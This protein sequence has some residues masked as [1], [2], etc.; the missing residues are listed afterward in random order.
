[1][2]FQERCSLYRS[3][4]SNVLSC[5]SFLKMTPDDDLQLFD[6]IAACLADDALSYP[7]LELDD[8]TQHEDTASE[9][10]VADVQALAPTKPRV[11][12]SRNFA[13]ERM[14]AELDELR[15]QSAELEKQFAE[16]N[17]QHMVSRDDELLL[18]SW[19][20]VALRQRNLRVRAEM[21]NLR[22]RQQ[23]QTHAVFSNELQQATMRIMEAGGGKVEDVDSSS[24]SSDTSSSTS[25]PASVPPTFPISGEL[26]PP[27]ALDTQH[28]SVLEVLVGE[29][30]T[31]Y[32]RT[33]SV[34]RENGL[35][36]WQTAAAAAN[37]CTSRLQAQMK[38]RR[39]VT[40]P[41]GSH[42]IE[43]LNASVQRYP[44]DV[45][46]RAAYRY[47]DQLNSATSSFKYVDL[48]QSRECIGSIAEF[49][50]TVGGDSSTLVFLG[51]FKTFTDGDGRTTVVWRSVSVE[52]PRF[53]GV[54]VSETAWEEY[55]NAGSSADNS[56]QIFCSQL[57]TRTLR[58]A[59]AATA[60]ATP[61]PIAL[62][63][64]VAATYEADM[65]QASTL[66]D[67]LLLEEAGDRTLTA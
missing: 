20:R 9:A 61:V 30:E 51:V 67:G 29:L 56:F 22:L 57:E 41:E 3:V 42:Y 35:R 5:Q 37:S 21:E 10:A 62:A 28:A 23:L 58:D 49:K 19:R 12:R 45:V 1:M 6:E 47:W 16:L 34:F 52:S 4:P 63:S 14:R 15:T 50:I 18:A 53:P 65:E 33:E 31:V 2:K 27:E 38:S 11:K 46:L 26:L 66:M 25:S 13:R 24:S 17:A 60:I 64:I 32:S 8:L 59:A 39:S 54:Y 48:D 43:L 7:L 36:E 40:S 44:K 55:S